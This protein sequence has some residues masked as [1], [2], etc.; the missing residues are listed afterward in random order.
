MKTIIS[1]RRA[2]I[3]S[4]FV[5]TIISKERNKVCKYFLYLGEYF[6]RQLLFMKNQKRSNDKG[7]ILREICVERSVSSRK[8]VIS[9]VFFST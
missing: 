8:Y 3:F 9:N 1:T 7:L 6:E 4:C 5:C 2:L